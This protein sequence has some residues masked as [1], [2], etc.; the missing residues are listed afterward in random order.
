MRTSMSRAGNAL[1]L[2]FSSLI[3]WVLLE[4]CLHLSVTTGYLDIEQPTYSLYNASSRFWVES[5]PVFGVWHTPHSSYRHVKSCFDVTYEANSYGARDR[6]RTRTAAGRRVVLL[7]D[8]FVEGLGVER[9]KR[10]SDL[11][12][13]DTK[14]E[15]LNFGTAGYFGPTQYYLLYKTLAKQF[16]HD[17]VI[18]GLFPTND[19]LDDDYEYGRR[20]HAHRYRP[21]LV[22]T[23]PDYQLI[24]H[25]E[26]LRT[27]GNRLGDAARYINGI[28][29]EFTYTY[30]VARYIAWRVGLRGEKRQTLTGKPRTYSGYYDFSAQQFD[31]MKYVLEQI[32]K[33]AEGKIVAIVTIPRRADLERY[34][35]VGGAPLARA[36]GALA[37]EVGAT[38]IDLLPH[39]YAHT[40]DWSRYYLPCDGHWNDYG[41]LT[42]YRYL[43]E[44]L[45]MYRRWS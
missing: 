36:L 20:V 4:V 5:H 41:H 25:R 21:Y 22:G 15:H 17:A 9:D 32:V 31:I 45:P 23:Y 38:Y 34:G 13:Q 27:E 33:E 39:F 29:R 42:A 1:L 16:D 28:L 11:L 44:Q 24:Y 30:N 14:L 37:E 6:E 8:S 43:R 26:T 18:I 35:V 2:L 40:K 3:A 7:G 12:E 10:L 19:F